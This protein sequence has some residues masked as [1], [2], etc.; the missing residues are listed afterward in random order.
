M[1]FIAYFAK[2]E[3]KS[4]KKNTRAM[5][6]NIR[7]FFDFGG[8]ERQRRDGFGKKK[9]K[10]NDLG[11]LEPPPYV[12]KSSAHISVEPPTCTENT[13]LMFKT[14]KKGDVSLH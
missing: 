13:R 6:L 10:K 4:D 7:K 2:I 12:L 9:K 5:L 3:F 8:L 11:V 14:I 1:F